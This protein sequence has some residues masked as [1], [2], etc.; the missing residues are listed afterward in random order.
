MQDQSRDI[1]KYYLD[2]QTGEVLYLDCFL[3]RQIEEGE[4]LDMELI[5]DWQ[6]GQIGEINA[7]L[8]DTEELYQRVP[9][10]WSNEAYDIMVDFIKTVPDN[11]I[12]DDLWN[13]I[14]GRKPFLRF[15]DALHQHPELLDS[16][17]TFEEK[18]YQKIIREWLNSFGIEPQ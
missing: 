12:A 7:I 9:E 11:R 16:W 10:V 18:A 3:F 15:K 4:E 2:T 8:E 6:Q 13:A 17:Y 14:Y 1:D 5:P